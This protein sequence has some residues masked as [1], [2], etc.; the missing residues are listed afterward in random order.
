V[1]RKRKRKRK[2]MRFGGI[3][4]NNIIY[5]KN[6]NQENEMKLVPIQPTYVGTCLSLPPK[7]K[8]KAQN[9]HTERE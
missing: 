1:R 9:T 5:N 6:L 8:E 4:I 3:Y 7:G 2:R